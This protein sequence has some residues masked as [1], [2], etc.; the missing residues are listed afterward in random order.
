MRRVFPL[1]PAILV[2]ALALAPRPSSA[3]VVERYMSA[4]LQGDL[5]GAPALFAGLDPDSAAPHEL[6]L[7]ERFRHRFLD[8]DE[9]LPLP[10]DPFVAEVVTCYRD[11]WVQVLLGVQEPAAAEAE[12]M[13]RLDATM[14]RYDPTATRPAGTDGPA[15][16]AVGAAVPDTVAPDDDDVLA[17]LDTAIERAGYHDISGR[18]RPH[19]ELML[20]ARQD[21]TRYDVQLTDTRRTVTVVFIGDFLVKG[22]TDFATF[23]HASTGGWATKDA[24]FCL[25]DDYDRDSEKFRISYLKHETRHF[26]DYE[27]F[28]AL[29]QIDLEYRAKLTELAFAETSLGDLL[30]MFEKQGEKNPAAPHSWANFAVVRDVRAELGMEAGTPTDWSAVAPDAVHRV[31]RTLLE[32]NTEALEAAGASTVRG[33]VGPAVGAPG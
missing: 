28:P 22:W 21:T 31:A 17:R 5:R 18:T 12:L 33:L 20:W 1:V 11:Y 13:K 30:E 6:E 2:A 25:G 9:E 3:G 8:R 29:Q 19:L 14:D 32:R 4:A 24:L 16:G 7:A 15:S 10:A 27:R 26:A 23:G